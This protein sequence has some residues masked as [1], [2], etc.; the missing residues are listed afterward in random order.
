ME[1]SKESRLAGLTVG[2]SLRECK[3]AGSSEC[4]AKRVEVIECE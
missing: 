2:H 4:E 1:E 3:S